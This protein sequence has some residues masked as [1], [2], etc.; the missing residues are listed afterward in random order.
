MRTKALLPELPG[1]QEV[2]GPLFVVPDSDVESGH[3]DADLVDSAG[4]VDNDLA[5][6]VVVHDLE[7]ADVA[8][9]HHDGEEADDDGGAGTEADLPLATLLGVVNALKSV[10]QTVHQNHLEAFVE[11][12]CLQ[13]DKVVNFMQNS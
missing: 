9:L 3:D 10:G 11:G 4:E 13:E 7:L 1:W 6:A 5:A 8:V 12:W 2:V